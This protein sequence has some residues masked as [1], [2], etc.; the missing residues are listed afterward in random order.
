MPLTPTKVLMGAFIVGTGL[1]VGYWTADEPQDGIRVRPGDE[2]I[3]SKRGESRLLGTARIEGPEPKASQHSSMP[4]AGGDVGEV[5][6]QAIRGSLDTDDLHYY[7]TL[8]NALRSRGCGELFRMRYAPRLVIPIGVDVDQ[9]L[10][11]PPSKLLYEWPSSVNH[12]HSELNDGVWKDEDLG[13][14]AFVGWRQGPRL[15]M[16]TGRP[17]SVFLPHTSTMVRGWIHEFAA[18]TPRHSIPKDQLVSLAQFADS[19]RAEGLSL[20]PRIWDRLVTSPTSTIRVGPGFGA[21]LVAA[22]QDGEIH[23]VGRGADP[24]LV[25]RLAELEQERAR[26]ARKLRELIGE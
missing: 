23:V 17:L 22:G 9:Y 14:F 8:A 1:L 24:E 13:G 2:S 19:W 15:V 16:V 3:D 10:S 4:S 26:V 6:A 21:D 20:L 11:K 25:D 5:A 7:E 12:R 18:D